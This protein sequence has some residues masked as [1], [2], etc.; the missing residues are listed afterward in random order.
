VSGRHTN[1][2]VLFGYARIST[3]DQSLG[4]QRAALVQAGVDPD[5]IFAE[6]AGGATLDRP[7][8]NS[9]LKALRPGDTLVVWKLDRLTR[10]L[11][12]ML[13]IEALLRE[14]GVGLRALTEWVDT[15]SP[16]GRLLFGIIGAVNQF[17]RDIIR[18]RTKAGLMAAKA[19]GKKLGAERKMTDAMVDHAIALMRSVTEGGEGLTRVAAAK[20]LGVGKST[21]HRE[22]AARETGGK[23]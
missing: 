22:L 3:E 12:D 10:N 6:T 16:A 9:A 13:R 11:A 19:A 1:P 15:S 18:E 20:R 17:E 4:M 2:G 14:R 7:G 21:L 8:L 23:A 5:R